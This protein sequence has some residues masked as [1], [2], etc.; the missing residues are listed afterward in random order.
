M[1]ERRKPVA[2]AKA[3]APAMAAAARKSAGG[4]EAVWKEF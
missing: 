4:D 1:A 2:R 3:A